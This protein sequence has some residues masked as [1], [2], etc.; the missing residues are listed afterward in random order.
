KT[1][2]EVLTAQPDDSAAANAPARE[3]QSEQVMAPIP[4][5]P[6]PADQPP[7]PPKTISKGDTKDYVVAA[8]GQP[9]R[10]VK[11]GAK[12]IYYYKDLKLMFLNG[13]VTDVQ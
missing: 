4:A 9:E 5:P 7:P 11:L 13:K 1:I 10:M 6:P 2:A 3:S 12:E 8:F